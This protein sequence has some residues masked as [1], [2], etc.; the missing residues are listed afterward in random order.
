MKKKSVGLLRKERKL[1]IFALS[2]KVL[3]N[4]FTEGH[5]SVFGVERG[6]PTGAVIIEVSATKRATELLVS[7]E[8]FKVVPDDLPIPYLKIQLVDLINP[9]SE[10]IH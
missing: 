4:I 2:N 7:S 3:K 1:A 8:K 5:A 9:L 6:I 10:T